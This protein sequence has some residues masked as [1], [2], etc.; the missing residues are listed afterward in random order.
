MV[1]RFALTGVGVGLTTILFIIFSKTHPMLYVLVLGLVSLQE[2]LTIMLFL[3]KPTEAK[4]LDSFAPNLVIIGKTE[5]ATCGKV[6]LTRAAISLLNSGYTE[7]DFKF[8][9]QVEFEEGLKRRALADIGKLGEVKIVTG[10]GK[11]P[12]SF[13]VNEK[14]ARKQEIPRIKNDDVDDLTLD[15]DFLEEE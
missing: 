4:Y 10:K 8:S 11:D 2:M 5:L 12:Y 7:G 13:C 9:T 6:S 15:Q 1:I 14:I 3:R